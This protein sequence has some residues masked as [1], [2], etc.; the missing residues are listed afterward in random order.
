M[1]GWLLLLLCFC[2]LGRVESACPFASD[3]VPN[4]TVVGPVYCAGRDL[5]FSS[6]NL[7][8]TGYMEATSL[9]IS[10][11][12]GLLVYDS[13]WN[14]SGSVV[15]NSTGGGASLQNMTVSALSFNMTGEGP[16]NGVLLRSVTFLGATSFNS[17]EITGNQTSGMGS[18]VELKQVEVRNVL[19]ASFK[20]YSTCYGVSI[21]SSLVVENSTMEVIGKGQSVGVDFS[22]AVVQAY[23]SILSFNG[24]G[25]SSVPCDAA[26]G[27]GVRIA[28]STIAGPQSCNFTFIGVHPKC[29]F[30]S[31]NF[32]VPCDHCHLE[33]NGF[34][35]T[36]GSPENS[37]GVSLDGSITASSLRINGTGS[38]CGARLGFS[39]SNGMDWH[40]NGYGAI[41][42]EVLP[43]QTIIGQIITILGFGSS[44]GIVIGEST[45]G[46][47]Y[48]ASTRLEMRAVD[49]NFSINRN[50]SLL[51][52]N[53]SLRV[54]S[55]FSITFK[56]VVRLMND[57]GIM[58]LFGRSTSTI[59]EVS[60]SSGFF[61]ID[62]Q[63]FVTQMVVSSPSFFGL[64]GT[65]S[66]NSLSLP[67]S[68]CS[69][70]GKIFVD[71][72]FNAPEFLILC[73]SSSSPSVLLQ[74]NS[75]VVLNSVYATIAGAQIAVHSP[76]IEFIGDVS[77][78]NHLSELTHTYP[79]RQRSPKFIFC[80]G[81]ES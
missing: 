54:D 31:S 62:G 78:E 69:F 24:E 79:D 2:G 4:A 43:K 47:L 64:I 19:R 10:S 23:R 12:V 30:C 3:L 70:C 75:K 68:R 42:V 67:N 37:T 18:G 40:V 27:A 81:I 65:L 20:G 77:R 51:L 26:E 60:G 9:A 41:G 8:I 72:I 58:T 29:G 53:C 63:F 25:V 33:I 39:Q 71:T 76:E 5:Q 80:R 35:R 50:I 15:V 57:G 13:V 14:I 1:F 73:G 74:S 34:A 28:N 21:H 6:V 22:S 55:E 16:Q 17:L 49:S 52:G 7:T 66:A 46:D 56:P 44:D 61:N 38:A 32:S 11:P 45:S 48:I 36:Y 59:F